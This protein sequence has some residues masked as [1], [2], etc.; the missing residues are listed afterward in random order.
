MANSVSNWKDSR[1]GV[2]QNSNIVNVL[3]GLS[4]KE[5]SF[6]KIWER[7]EDQKGSMSFRRQDQK[8]QKSI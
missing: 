5:T 7:Q 8:Q 6:T 1:N 2:K 3:L 4:K